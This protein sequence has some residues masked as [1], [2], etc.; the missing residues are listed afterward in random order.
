MSFFPF[1]VPFFADLNCIEQF[2]DAK[3]LHNRPLPSQ[4]ASQTLPLSL[5]SSLCPSHLQVI[6]ATILP[7]TKKV[8]LQRLAE[9]KIIHNMR[10]LFLEPECPAIKLQSCAMPSSGFTLPSLSP[11]FRDLDPRGSTFTCGAGCKGYK[12]LP[13]VKVEISIQAYKYQN[14]KSCMCIHFN[15]YPKNITSLPMMISPKNLEIDLISQKKKKWVL[16]L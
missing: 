3:H 13:P 6:L 9:Q 8:K 1:L 7:A 2:L 4:Y 14:L 10:D 5:P 11:A 12:N 15:I 16:I